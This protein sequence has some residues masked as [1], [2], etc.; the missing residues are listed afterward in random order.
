M[1]SPPVVWLLVASACAT[2]ERTV[3]RANV[4][5]ESTPTGAYVAMTDQSG[6][7][8][9]GQAPIDVE[10]VYATETMV[11][12][13]GVWWTPLISGVVTVIGVALAASSDFGT[14]ATGAASGAAIGG[15]VMASLGGSVFLVALPVA[16][17]L[18]AADDT[19]V[20]RGYESGPPTF[21]ASLPGYSRA[22][23][24]LSATEPPPK[25]PILLGLHPVGGLAGG[26]GENLGVLGVQG[27]AS[28]GTAGGLGV[29]GPAARPV[30]A[31]FEIHDST[32]DRRLAR[33]LTQYL[34][35]RLAEHGRFRVV[36]DAAL[37]ERLSEGKTASYSSCFDDRCQ[38]E[39]GKAVAAS[40]SL[41]TRVLR[42]GSTCTVSSSLFDLKTEAAETAASVRSSCTH[43]GLLD[44]LDKIAAKLS[45][46]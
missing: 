22:S 37:R 15:L 31:V 5:I 39:I 14:D 8:T 13:S 2:T 35:A 4:R 44:A 25:Q 30:I 10:L 41:A 29:L 38:I 36:P 26:L 32:L 34:G 33:E 42:V 24:V 1:R 20:S 43:E 18:S 17:A 21:E 46:V 3:E 23:A 40:K 7:R 6:S 16:L 12:G 11:T 45:G 19:V 9:L 28:S 27:G